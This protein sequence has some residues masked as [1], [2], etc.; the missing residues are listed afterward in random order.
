MFAMPSAQTV[1]NSE[2]TPTNGDTRLRCVDAGLSIGR[3]VQKAVVVQSGARDAYQLALALS[4]RDMLEA[5]V[6]DLFWPGDQAWARALLAVLPQNV[7]SL[8]SQRSEARLPW[9]Q[10][11][12]CAVTGI[13]TLLLD[14][15]PR[16]SS[17]VRQEAM[18]SADSELGTTAGTLARKAGA[19]LVSYSYYGY[20]AFTAY[21][22]G[23]ILFQLHPHPASM[24]R[25]LGEELA[26]HPDCAVSLRQE[27]EL[28]LS[29]EDF[30]H[31]VAETKMASR[32]LVASSF[33]KKTL[34]EN[35]AAPELITVVPYGVDITRFFPDPQRRSGSKG[36]LRLLFVGRINQR[37]GIKY[38]LEAFQMVRSQDIEL[39]VCG[40]VVDGLEL[41]L[42]F[43]DQIKVRPS[44]SAVE[45]LAAYQSADLFVFP[46]VA[47]G[48]GQV[49]LESLACG[50]PILSTTHT[51]APDL[52]DEGVE[53][54]I[55]EPRRP[56]LIAER[57]RWALEH[58]EELA[59]MG[60]AARRR[61]E[62]FTWQRFRTRI[63][64]TVELYLDPG[65][66]Q[67]TRSSHV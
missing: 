44:V 28:A 4:E 40:R 41:F 19:G 23:A 8:L 5:L 10:I 37:K 1:L 51:A 7:K 39:T 61:A 45:L 34:V 9:R 29:E 13:K 56:D 31:L 11:K 33:T 48:F 15:L 36:K 59:R 67:Q 64:D 43:A 65:D 30:Q 12:L 14:K 55:V 63:A 32:F 21:G 60:E 3:K 62:A 24:R 27:W 35:G 58:R 42:P 6:T 66:L 22:R 25:I 16:V 50:L 54:F 38:L 26:V 47:E 52:I 20:D 18:R 17:K 46:S 53:G 57:I 49:I 2:I